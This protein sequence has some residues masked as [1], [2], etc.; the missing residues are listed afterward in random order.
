MLHVWFVVPQKAT[1]GSE[2]DAMAARKV[3]FGVARSYLIYAI[4]KRTIAD[5]IRYCKT[6]EEARER[7]SCC[8]TATCQNELDGANNRND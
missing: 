4:R 2:I 8:G 6:N 1:I 3:T 7:R 5:A